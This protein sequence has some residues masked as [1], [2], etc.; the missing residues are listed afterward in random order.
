MTED[1]TNQPVEV[2]IGKT[3]IL[4]SRTFGTQNLHEIYSDYV[5]RRIRETARNDKC[6]GVG[7]MRVGA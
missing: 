2:P 1:K 5:A 7:E 4:I 6:S 3:K